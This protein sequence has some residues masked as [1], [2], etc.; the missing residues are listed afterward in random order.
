MRVS[1]DPPLGH[2]YGFPK[3]H[4]P[5][6]HGEDICEWLIREGYPQQQMLQFGDRFYWRSW[7]ADAKWTHMFR[8]GVPVTP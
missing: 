2:L 3:I 7:P 1:I 5:Q 8:Q 4:D 6:L